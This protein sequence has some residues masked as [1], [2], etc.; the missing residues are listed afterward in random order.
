MANHLGD[1]VA[2]EVDS[3]PVLLRL[4]ED[5]HLAPPL[6]LWPVDLDDEVV[7]LSKFACINELRCFWRGSSPPA[8]DAGS[9]SNQSCPQVYLMIVGIEDDRDFLVGLRVGN[10]RDSG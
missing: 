7:S 10:E 5:L 1:M 3:F 8:D 6:L 9:T 2:N 4:L